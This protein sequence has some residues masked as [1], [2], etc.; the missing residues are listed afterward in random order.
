MEAQPILGTMAQVLTPQASIS[1]LQVIP[2]IWIQCENPS[3]QGL[4]KKRKEMETGTKESA[5]MGRMRMLSG[6]STKHSRSGT[7]IHLVL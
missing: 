4:G 3:A 6:A 7:N 5:A 1:S 2:T